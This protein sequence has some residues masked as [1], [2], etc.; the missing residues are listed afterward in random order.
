MTIKGHQKLFWGTT[1]EFQRT[2]DIKSSVL[3]QYL[4]YNVH[5]LFH[6]YEYLSLGIANIEGT[7]RVA[8]SNLFLVYSKLAREKS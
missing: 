5:G 7:S 8:Q 2:L 1:H 4:S 3:F 6:L